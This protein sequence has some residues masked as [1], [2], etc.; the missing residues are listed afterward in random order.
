MYNLILIFNI[1]SIYSL[2]RENKTKPCLFVL[3]PVHCAKMP[4]FSKTRSPAEIVRNLKDA[5]TTLERGGETKKQ[6]KVRL[7]K[8]VGIPTYRAGAMVFRLGGQD[9]LLVQIFGWANPDFLAVFLT[10]ILLPWAKILA[11]KCI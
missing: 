7:Q 11:R 8:Q 4:L 1:T 10:Q 3:V 2:Q 5:L 9:P 6:E